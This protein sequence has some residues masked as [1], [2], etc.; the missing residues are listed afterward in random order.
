[1][2]KIILIV[3]L[4]L[5]LLLVS[6][7]LSVHIRFG[8]RNSNASVVNGSTDSAASPQEEGSLLDIIAIGGTEGLDDL[9]AALEEADAF[10]A[11]GQNGAIPA[12]DALPGS[13]S[14]LGDE[15]GSAAPDAPF[16][17]P[18]TIEAAPLFEGYGYYHWQCTASG[19]YTFLPANSDGVTWEVYLLDEEFTDAERYIPQTTEKVLEGEGSLEIAAGKWIYVYCPCNSWTC[20]EAPSGCSMTVVF[21]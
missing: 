17:Q 8:G 13:E 3:V 14:S 6:V 20:L 11:A 5:A 7:S 16:A 9:A 18:V 10:S 1:M 19:V 21:G 4:V 2:K 15:A 12:G